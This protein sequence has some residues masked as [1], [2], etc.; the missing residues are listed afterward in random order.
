MITVEDILELVGTL[1]DTPRDNTA[2]SRFRSYLAKSACTVGII[3]DYI[4]L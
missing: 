1:D 2:R 3:R 4:T